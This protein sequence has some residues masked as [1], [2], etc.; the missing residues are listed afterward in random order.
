MPAEDIDRVFEKFY[1]ASGGNAGGTGLGLTITKGFVEAHHGTISAR[2]RPQGGAEF[3]VKLPLSE[4]V[5]NDLKA[6]V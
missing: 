5:S 3:I 2:N 4:S 1:R 6:T